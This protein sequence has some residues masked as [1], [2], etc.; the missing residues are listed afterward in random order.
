M[1]R[2]IIALCMVF[3]LMISVGFVMASAKNQKFSLP[4]NAVK[5]APG[6]FYLGK[7]FDKGKFVEG[8][9]FMMKDEKRFAKPNSFCGDGICDSRENI[10]K[11]PVDCG[12]SEDPVEPDTS[13]CYEFL[14]KGAKWKTVENYLV[15]PANAKG[16]G[17]LFIRSNL[18]S[19]IGKW[20]NAGGRDILGNE[21]FGIVERTKLYSLNNK[22]EMMFGDIDSPGA[23][24]VTIVWGTFGSPPPFRELV[25]WDMVFDDV[26]FDWS[27][28]RESNKMDFENIATHELGHVVGMGDLYSDF[29]SQ[30]TMYGYSWNGDI[31]KRDLADGDIAGIQKLYN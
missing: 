23:I 29:C 21:I 18:A 12:G 25:E 19:N 5:V 10:N 28:M 13:S 9:A 26:D 4:E 27:S 22:N 14:A 31:I 11:C 16:L 20:E 2:T 8:Y 7:T 1:K 6:V 17:E 3:I 24:G 15:D 30:Q